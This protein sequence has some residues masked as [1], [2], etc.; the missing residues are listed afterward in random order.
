M[1]TTSPVRVRLACA[2]A[3]LG[4]AL[5]ALPALTPPAQAAPPSA[6]RVTCVDTSHHNHGPAERTPIDWRRV[7]RDHGFAF[8]KAT[9][10]TRY[11][12]P[13]FARDHAAAARTTLLRAPY[14]FFDPR[15]TTDGAAQARHFVATARAAGYQGGRP[16]ELPPVLDVE[17]VL[18]DGREVCPPALR[19]QQIRVFLNEVR[20]AFGVTPIVYTRASFVRECMAGKGEVFAGHPLWLARYGSGSREPQPVPGAGGSWT[21]WQH[22]DRGSTP[23]IPGKTDLDVFR[24]GPAELRALAGRGA[25]QPGT[26]G[27]PTLRSG[28]RGVDVTTAQLL[29]TARGHQVPADGVFGPRTTTQVKAFQQAAG[30]P[31]D[32]LVGARTWAALVPTLSPDSRGKAVEAAQRQLTANGHTVPADGVFGPR[33]T[34]QVKAFQRAAGLPVDGVVGPRTWAALVGRS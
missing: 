13:W 5:A 7:A 25:G 9:Q 34:T 32:G 3:A 15:G 20:S 14:H 24:G 8:L 12:D 17:K 28:A 26:A 27:W 1:V 18:R 4:A 6:Y 31:V 10:G 30:L 23:G 2:A 16:G 33:T 22:T 11:K 19:A 21:F 29:L